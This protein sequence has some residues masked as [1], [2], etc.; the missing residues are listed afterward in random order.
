MRIKKNQIQINKE[1]LHIHDCECCNYVG[2]SKEHDIYYCDGLLEPVM[3]MR[4]GSEGHEY[5]SYSFT[6]LDMFE[7][8]FLDCELNKYLWYQ[9]IKKL[10]RL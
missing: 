8:Y 7:T 6:Q 10:K 2:S 1:K 3:I 9:E 4:Y 5:K